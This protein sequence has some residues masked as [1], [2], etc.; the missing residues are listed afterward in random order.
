MKRKIATKIALTIALTLALGALLSVL[1][2]VPALAH[3]HEGE[4]RQTPLVLDENVPSV[5]DQT[6]KFSWEQ[7]TK[8]LTLF[9]FSMQ[10]VSAEIKAICLPDGATIR[11]EEDTVNT[12][13]LPASEQINTGFYA[14]YC[15]G[16]LTIEEIGRAHV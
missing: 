11:L 15:A 4:V 1:T 10:Y 13:V 8:T 12:I 7:D 3:E 2:A 14:I 5:N 6:Q 9:G 16:D